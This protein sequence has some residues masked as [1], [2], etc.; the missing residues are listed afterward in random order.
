VHDKHMHRARC[1][2]DGK[3]TDLFNGILTSAENKS[4]T[5]SSGNLAEVVTLN[6]L[7]GA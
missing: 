3:V 1:K 2:L 6:L 4:V 5:F 7:V